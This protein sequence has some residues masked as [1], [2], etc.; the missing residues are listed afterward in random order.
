M[1]TKYHDKKFPHYVAVRLTAKQVKK[2]GEN[3]S[4]TIRNLIDNYDH[5]NL[6][7]KVLN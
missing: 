6:G 7:T 4:Q 3:R 5:K 2:L 1:A